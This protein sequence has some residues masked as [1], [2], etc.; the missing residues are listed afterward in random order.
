M[1]V[2]ARAGM[3]LMELVI[4]LAIT[5][6]M[7]AAG[8]GAFASIID[9]KRVIST[10]TASTERATSIRETIRS[11]AL[12]GNVRIQIGGIPRGLASGAARTAGRGGAAG[13][14]N[15]SMNVANV[16]PAKAAGDEL[17]IAGVTAVNPSMQPSVTIRLYIDADENTPEKGLTMEYQPQVQLPLVRRMLDS[18]IDV[19]TVEY[20]DIRT[21]RWIASSQAATL[22][23]G[24]AVRVTLGSSSKT[25]ASAIL[26]VPMV[27][28]SNL[29][30]ANT[31]R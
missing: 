15:G 31:N 9:H 1:I 11:W 7:A 4:G 10:A 16:T 12:S 30:T 17:T 18:T 13:A 5:G 19:L 27:F 23:G 3:T 8:A 21:K 20:L 14:T 6:L 24:S 28:T 25:G 29:Q 26:G 22:S 2:R